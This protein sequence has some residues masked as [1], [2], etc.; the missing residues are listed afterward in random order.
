VASLPVS[1]EHEGV[2]RADE[3]GFVCLDVGIAAS[4]SS[5]SSGS[6]TK[7]HSM[8]PNRFYDIPHEILQ[9]CARD[10]IP[11]L[12]SVGRERDGARLSRS[13]GPVGLHIPYDPNSV[14]GARRGHIR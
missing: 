11:F 4:R 10:N 13:A 5:S 6:T 1:S 7:L 14:P 2:G 12:S 8:I 9:I 3:I